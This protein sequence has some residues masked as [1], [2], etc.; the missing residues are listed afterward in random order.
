MLKMVFLESL[1]K[2]NPERILYNYTIQGLY[3]RH[4]EGII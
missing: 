1:Q 3:T 2:Q 4:H